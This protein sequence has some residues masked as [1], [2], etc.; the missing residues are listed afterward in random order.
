MQIERATEKSYK[1]G[2]MFYRPEPYLVVTYIPEKGLN[3]TIVWLPNYSD[4]YVIRPKGAFGS[5]E[6]NVTLENGW[7]LT[8]LGLVR[9]SKVPET[10]ASITGAVASAAEV[11]KFDTAKDKILAPGLYRIIFTNG[12]VSGLQR[13]NMQ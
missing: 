4:G 1:D 10:I 3:N 5:S 11:F 8:D 13:I 7:N 12:V 2:L 9:D 6:I